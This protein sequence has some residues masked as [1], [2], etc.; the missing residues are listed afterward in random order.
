[1]SEHIHYDDDIKHDIGSNKYGY[2]GDGPYCLQHRTAHTHVFIKEQDMTCACTLAHS[3]AYCM[4]M[5][6]E[7]SRD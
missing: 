4:P 7:S 2:E 6:L 3:A 1:M 5:G